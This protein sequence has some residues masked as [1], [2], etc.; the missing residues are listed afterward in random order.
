MA[1]TALAT[2]KS[3]FQR[4]DKPTETQFSDTW[5]SFWHKL[6]TVPKSTIELYETV[7]HPSYV[8]T[9]SVNDDGSFIITVKYKVALGS[10]YGLTLI[11]VANAQIFFTEYSDV[12]LDSVDS[13]AQITLSR[14]YTETT[15]AT[16]PLLYIVYGNQKG[17]YQA[18][19]NTSFFSQQ[20]YDPGRNLYLDISAVGVTMSVV[21]STGNESWRRLTLKG[22]YQKN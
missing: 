13:S 3:W 17:M 9:R 20:D 6:E 19:H 5:D 2:I 4:Q 10:A 15:I 22:Y 18:Y 12:K 7:T 11:P 14:F 16:F 21:S 1:I 8:I